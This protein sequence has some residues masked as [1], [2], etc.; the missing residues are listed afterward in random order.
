MIL[1]TKNGKNP[2]MKRINRKKLKMKKK[3]LLKL[4]S[5]T[6]ALVM[7]YCWQMMRSQQ[8][9]KSI[10]MIIMTSATW[11]WMIGEIKLILKNRKQKVK[12]KKRIHT[13][14]IHYTYIIYILYIYYTYI[15][16]ILYIINILYELNPYLKV[17]WS[18]V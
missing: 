17:L 8:T 1:K 16:H 18:G 10:I 3:V 13:L 6:E 4:N 7:N 9:L 12:M 14:Y 2:M 5:E 11:R 15:I